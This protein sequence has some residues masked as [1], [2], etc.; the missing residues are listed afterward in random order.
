[1]TNS[2]FF[3]Y[4]NKLIKFRLKRSNR[5]NKGVVLDI[6]DYAKKKYSTHYIFIPAGSLL[7][8]KSASKNGDSALMN[9]IEEEVDIQE[10]DKAELIDLAS[11][12]LKGIEH[13]RP[14]TI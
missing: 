12:R 14:E 7:D 4:H 13:L 8:W 2:D 1:M 10:I 9:N 6:S 5:W 11:L 3:P